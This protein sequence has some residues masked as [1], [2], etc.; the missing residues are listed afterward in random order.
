VK[1]GHTEKKGRLEMTKIWIEEAECLVPRKGT[2][3]KRL[4]LQEDLRKSD[5]VLAVDI[6]S[7]PM[8]EDPNGF[9]AGDHCATFNWEWMGDDENVRCWR[10]YLL[11]SAL[12]LI[13]HEA[14]GSVRQHSLTGVESGDWIDYSFYSKA[15]Y[16]FSV[17]K[18]AGM[19]P[20]DSVLMN[21][22]E[23]P[24]SYDSKELEAA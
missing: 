10:S 23:Q 20:A 17:L 19:R 18:D 13:K 22:S 12:P 3:E 9:Y 15:S 6:E 16:A 24:L 8:Y 21:K 14:L 11:L 1:Q 2:Q 7:W 4:K 5:P